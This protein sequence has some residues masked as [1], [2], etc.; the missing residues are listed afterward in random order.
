MWLCRKVAPILVAGDAA[1]EKGLKTR[2]GTS[3]ADL[4]VR[5]QH[6]APVLGRQQVQII[7]M[8]PRADRQSCDLRCRQWCARRRGG[9]AAAP[10][11]G[12]EHLVGRA[13]AL[14]HFPRLPQQCTIAADSLGPGFRQRWISA[15]CRARC[16]RPRSCGSSG[17][18]WRP[19]RRQ[20]GIRIPARRARHIAARRQAT[21]PAR[22]A[23][24]E[25]T[26]GLAAPMRS[27]PA[28]PSS[29]IR[30][31]APRRARPQRRAP[32]CRQAANP[33]GTSRWREVASAVL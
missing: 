32:D 4:P 7:T 31:A 28:A 24:D 9:K 33:G 8:S 23:N 27:S 25:A 16:A 26:T 13:V 30:P 20:R 2:L 11:E 18:R 12:G 21:D 29:R 17:R 3:L 5:C 22:Q 6:L 14:L 15:P 10:V 1:I 19:S